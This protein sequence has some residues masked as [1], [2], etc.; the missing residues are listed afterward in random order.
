MSS[1]SFREV[2][3]SEAPLQGRAKPES[4]KSRSS[5]DGGS[6]L[7]KLPQVK[8]NSTKN[9]DYSSKI[10]RFM[11]DTF[12]PFVTAHADSMRNENFVSGGLQE[13]KVKPAEAAL[14]ASAVAALLYS[15]FSIASELTDYSFLKS[16]SEHLGPDFATHVSGEFILQILVGAALLLA[17][18]AA[19]AIL[20]RAAT[21][22]YQA[23]KHLPELERSLLI[24]Q[25]LNEKD[26]PQPYSEIDRTLKTPT[27]GDYL[28][29][30][31]RGFTSGLWGKVGFDYFIDKNLPRPKLPKKEVE[32]GFEDSFG[33]LYDSKSGRSR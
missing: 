29:W 22:A 6:F 10:V 15:G 5:V 30:A 9:S 23:A 8:Q 20:A 11:G 1:D 7:P 16:F 32:K 24:A 31:G 26:N 4:S 27:T 25:K 18:V 3:Q 33:E 13:L 19:A 12:L 28:K 14:A 17:V 2:P 21:Q